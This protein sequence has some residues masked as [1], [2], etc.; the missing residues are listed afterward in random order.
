MFEQ[1]SVIQREFN[2]KL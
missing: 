2:S 1:N